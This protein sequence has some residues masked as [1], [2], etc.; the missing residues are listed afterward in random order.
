MRSWPLL[1]P[2]CAGTS[3]SLP[4]C[5]HTKALHRQWVGRY[6]LFRHRENDAERVY[7]LQPRTHSR[8]CQHQYLSSI[9]LD[10]KSMYMLDM[11]HLCLKSHT[12]RHIRAHTRMHTHTHT[13]PFL[14]Y[15]REKE[16]PPP[17][18]ASDLH[19][20][21]H[22]LSDPSKWSG[23]GSCEVSLFLC[24]QERCAFFPNSFVYNLK[25][26]PQVSGLAQKQ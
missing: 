16:V 13:L 4:C 25:G 7:L 21:S 19:I 14:V 8:C 23:N 22:C 24:I 9:Y 10:S 26:S 18:S 20:L 11:C 3:Y 2:L 6:S 12:C 1:Y 15:H 5:L 17:L